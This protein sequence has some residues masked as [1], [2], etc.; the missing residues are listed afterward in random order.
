MVPFTVCLAALVSTVC[1]AASVDGVAV[2][3]GDH[4]VI[5]Q[6][7]SLPGDHAVEGTAW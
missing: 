6:T 5:G 7:P 1:L 3:T 4:A 2:A